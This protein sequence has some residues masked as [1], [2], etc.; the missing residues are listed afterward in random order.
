MDLLLDTHIIL[1]AFG[2]PTRLCSRVQ[3]AIQDPSNR[4]FLSVASVWEIQVKTQ[5]GKLKFAVSVKDL[6]AVQRATN[7]IQSLPLL[8][9][10]IWAL[11][12]LPMHHKDPFDRLIMAQALIEGYQIV[13]VDP[14]FEQYPVR[15]FR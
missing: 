3:N 11:A 14:L 15:L 1:W 6:I 4:L 7:D 8:E 2:E 12:S 9:R 5:I 10:H 13:T